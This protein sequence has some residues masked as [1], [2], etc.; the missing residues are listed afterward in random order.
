MSNFGNL[1][2]IAKKERLYI[3]DTIKLNQ[4]ND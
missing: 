4:F 3:S 1:I 2:L